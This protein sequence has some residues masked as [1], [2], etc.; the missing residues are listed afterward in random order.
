MRNF[1]VV[2][3]L[4]CLT[5]NVFAESFSSTAWSLSGLIS[6]TYSTTIPGVTLRIE[7]ASSPDAEETGVFLGASTSIPLPNW[8]EFAVVR[9]FVDIDPHSPT[10]KQKLQTNW[11]LLPGESRVVYSW[12]VPGK[13]IFRLDLVGVKKSRLDLPIGNIGTGKSPVFQ[14]FSVEF[15]VQEFD[16]E[17]SEAQREYFWQRYAAQGIFLR[18]EKVKP[19]TPVIIENNIDKSVEVA[20]PAV[21]EKPKPVWAI[22][23]VGFGLW[24]LKFSIAPISVPKDQLDQLAQDGKIPYRFVEDKL[25][26]GN[27]AIIFQNLPIGGCYWYRIEGEHRG[28]PGGDVGNWQVVE[29]DPRFNAVINRQ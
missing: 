18:R 13:N 23:F 27:R 28:A 12:L 7:F 22:E 21:V 14:S 2:V 17:L 20:P 15:Y 26:N 3:F 1:A 19:I 4:V 29:I 24:P 5:V 9:I 8:Q 11:E 25:D 16:G 6:K 10:S